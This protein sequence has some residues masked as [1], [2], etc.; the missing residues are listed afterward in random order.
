MRGNDRR[1]IYRE[2]Q[3]LLGRIMKPEE[4]AAIDR[5]LDDII[6]MKESAR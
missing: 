5:A 2:V 1:L 3:V 4:R 6:A